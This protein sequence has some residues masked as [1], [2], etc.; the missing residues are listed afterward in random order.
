MFKSDSVDRMEE[1]FADSDERVLMAQK[2]LAVPCYDDLCQHRVHRTCRLLLSCR[3]SE[4]CSLRATPPIADRRRHVTPPIIAHLVTRCAGVQVSS[5]GRR[6]LPIPQACQG[7]L[8]FGCANET[9][10][11]FLHFWR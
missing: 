3:G 4:S 5:G 2:V 10:S 11:H 8:R 9:Q 6:E 7:A 1:L